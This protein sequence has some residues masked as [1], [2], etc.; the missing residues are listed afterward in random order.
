VIG[1]TVQ[2]R[3]I[4]AYIIGTGPKKIFLFGAMHGDEKNTYVLL[5][6]V[7]S[8]LDGNSSNIPADKQII[9]VPV[10]N[11]DGFLANNRFNANHVD[12]NR[13]SDTA[14]WEHDSYIGNT[15]VNGGGGPTP[16]S[17]PETQTLA[18]IMTTDRPYMTVSYHSSAAYVI[19]NGKNLSGYRAKTYAGMIGYRYIPYESSATEGFNYKI[20]GDF[21][22]WAH[23]H[24]LNAFTVEL[25][26]N[27]D[28]EFS[29]Q[30]PAIWYLIKI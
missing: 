12:I 21:T 3:D 30:M 10:L 4:N 17:E 9:V 26:T 8:Y 16:G 24:T 13:N 25:R 1:H 27:T 29:R 19:S 2:G 18:S 22:V 5:S 11:V 20:T 28:D 15:K 6:K 14:D 23:E 7:V